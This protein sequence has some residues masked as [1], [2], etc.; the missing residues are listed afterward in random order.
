[1]EWEQ[2]KGAGR[3]TVISLPAL[4]LKALV[5]FSFLGFLFLLKFLWH[6]DLQKLNTCEE[7]VS[8]IGTR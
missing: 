5:H 1:M 4:R 6:F 8:G 7:L 3:T 2:G